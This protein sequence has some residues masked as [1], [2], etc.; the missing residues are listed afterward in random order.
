M[1]VYTDW[2]VYVG[3]FDGD[4]TVTTLGIPTDSVDF[5]SR[6]VGFDADFKIALGESGR[7]SLL[8]E[9]DNSDGALTPG[10]GGAYSSFDWFKQPV[11]LIPKAGLTDPPDTLLQPVYPSD[12]PTFMGQI[13]DFRYADDG[14]DSTVVIKAEDW[15]SL[16][17]RLTL[18]ATYTA[19][20]VA[21]D[22]AILTTTN[23]DQLPTFGADTTA[24]FIRDPAGADWVTVSASESKGAFIADIVDTL[25]LSDGGFLYPAWFQAINSVGL[26]WIFFWYEGVPRSYLANDSDYPYETQTFKD[27]GNIG[28][29]ELPFNNLRLGFTSDQLI[30]QAEVNRAGGTAQY[31]FNDSVSTTYGP[32]SI[33]LLELMMDTDTDAL[34]MAEFYTSR[35]NEVEFTVSSFEVTSGQIEQYANDGALNQ[36]KQLMSRSGPGTGPLYKPTTVSWTYRDDSTA[37]EVVVPVRQKI[38]G[39]PAGWTMSFECL[40]ATANFGFILDDDSLGVLDQNRLG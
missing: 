6:M 29:A 39:T 38:S 11:W 10:G 30:T 35:Y 19:S 18:Q 15:L 4:D 14:F 20:S 36:V 33:Q 8:V 24:R 27:V 16:N 9:L 34:S 21:V 25:I 5:T 22:Q 7:S 40:P 32:R 37:T 28:T 17:G 23:L 2:V 13:S 12:T 3:G 26:S 1:T 31:S